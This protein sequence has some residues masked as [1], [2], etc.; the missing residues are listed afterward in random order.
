MESFAQ[1]VKAMGKLARSKTVSN[2]RTIMDTAT[3][4]TAQ[5]S[6]GASDSDFQMNQE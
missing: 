4:E 2:L 5:A 1:G 6:N 3:V